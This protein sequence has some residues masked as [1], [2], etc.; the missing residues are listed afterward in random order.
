MSVEINVQGRTVLAQFHSIGSAGNV[1]DVFFHGYANYEKGI[2]AQ[3][4][5]LTSCNTTGFIRAY[6]E[7]GLA[8]VFPFDFLG[9][10]FQI[11]A[12]VIGN[13]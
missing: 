13:P 12:V 11:T 2:G 5:K 1:A 9:E 8:E 4:L 10:G 6:D 7:N 3:F